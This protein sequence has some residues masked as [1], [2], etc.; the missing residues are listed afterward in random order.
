VARISLTSEAQR[1]PLLMYMSCGWFFPDISRIETVQVLKYARRVLDFMENLGI[2]APTNR[3]LET[4]AR[5]RRNLPMRQ[6]GTNLPF[7]VE[8]CVTSAWTTT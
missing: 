5:H 2:G 1:A 7:E 8:P 6:V 3:F 4:E